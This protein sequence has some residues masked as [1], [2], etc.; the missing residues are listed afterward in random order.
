MRASDAQDLRVTLGADVS[1]WI[2]LRGLSQSH[3]KQA[4]GKQISSQG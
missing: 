2:H 4:P 3:V 1:R